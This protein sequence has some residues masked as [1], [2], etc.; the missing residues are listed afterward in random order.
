M[1]LNF[2]EKQICL[3]R[4]IFFF[5][6]MA[7][8]FT[9]SCDKENKKLNLFSVQDDIQFG[10]E[11]DQQI[12]TSG[13][14]T[15]ASETQYAEAYSILNQYKNKLL[16]TGKVAYADQFEWKV[17]IIKDDATINAFAVPGGYLY[18][19]TGLMKAL[20]NE[21]E[22]VGVM[23][24]EMA[25][26]ARRHSTEQLTKAYGVDLM[27]SMLLGKNQNQWVQIASGLASGLASLQFSRNDEYE[28]DKYA[29]MYTYPTD[30]DARG[31]GD[32]FKKMDSHTSTPVFLSTHPSD[33]QRVKKI[34]EEWARLGEK[35]GKYFPD[36]YRHF[37]SVLP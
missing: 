11:F 20:D 21:A 34:D 18:F 16:S 17:R 22:F 35:Q 10:K 4:K 15:V 26:I 30:W 9:F 37:R 36:L 33:A 19:Y 8:L 28:A 1:K 23:A 24:H 3:I 27:L 12:L 14:F 13:E 25:H 6:F 31:V 2:K 7:T 32:F 5:F 29:V